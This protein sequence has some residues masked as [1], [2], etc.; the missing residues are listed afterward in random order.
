MSNIKKELV[1]GLFFTAISKYSALTVS[2]VVNIILARLLTPELFGVMAV[3]MVFITFFS[4]LSDLGIGPAIIQKD[5]LTVKDHAHIFS[6][7]VWIGII[8]SLAFFFSAWLIS[9]WYKNSLLLP[10]FKLLSINVLF[11][12]INIVPNALLLKAKKFKF[13]AVRTFIIQFLLGV[14]SCVAAYCGLGIYSLLINPILGSIFVFVVNYNKFP[15]RFYWVI[16]MDSIRIIFSFSVYQFMFNFVN[17]FTRNL[18]KI[19]IGKYIGMVSLG[20]YEKSYRLM[21]LPLQNITFVITPVIQPVLSSYQKDLSSL[22]RYHEKI[23]RLLSFL[24]FPLSVFLFFSARELV[25][26]TFGSQ[27]IDSIPVFRILALTVGF[28]I[29]L[30]TVGSFYQITDSTKALFATGLINSTITI[31]GL[32]LAIFSYET[33][34]AVAYALMITIILSFF[35]SYYVLIKIIFKGTFSG[36][37]KNLISPLVLSLIMCLL[38]FCVS[39]IVFESLFVMLFVKLIFFSLLLFVY[40]MIN[41][42]LKMLY[43]FLKIRK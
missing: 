4:I 20:Y 36:F 5:E 29:L 2:L 43:D 34:T 15:Q 13:I 3:A 14:V 16:N 7:T 21:L 25:L 26:L 38:L 24:A 6:L 28:Q 17:Y 12:T 35:N 42:K 9:S 31:I 39:K 27:W 33:I 1:S 37:V 32:L 40:L 23:I 18:D 8:L 41:D 22:A 19:L 30:S 10:V 11:A